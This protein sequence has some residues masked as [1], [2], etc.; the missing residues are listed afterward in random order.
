MASLSKVVPFTNRGL[1]MSIVRHRQWFDHE[2]RAWILQSNL[3]LHYIRNTSED[4]QDEDKKAEHTRW[5]RI[6]EEQRV[7]ETTKPELGFVHKVEYRYGEK[8]LFSSLGNEKTQVSFNRR[9]AD[10][11]KMARKRNETVLKNRM[12]NKSL[13]DRVVNPPL[14]E[15]AEAKMYGMDLAAV[16]KRITDS[17][18]PTDIAAV[19][20]GY[21]GTS[22]THIYDAWWANMPEAQRQKMI[23]ETRCKWNKLLNTDGTHPTPEASARGDIYQK[24]A[25]IM[26]QKTTAP[27]QPKSV[28]VQNLEGVIGSQ[29]A[30]VEF[31]IARRDEV[32]ANLVQREAKVLAMIG[33]LSALERAL[34]EA[35][36]V[37]A[38]KRK[39]KK[40]VAK[41]KPVVKPKAV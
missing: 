18:S 23:E 2:K 17:M 1:K 24:A 34:A 13:I 3:G 27:E 19:Q 12:W 16:E 36:R 5:L 29:R 8:Y 14:F 21:N 31:A 35:N 20:L 30:E 9:A 7:M 37:P 22:T 39:A 28:Y 38:K 40:K 26:M 32:K 15:Q 10:P 33:L 6:R 41:N 11:Y 25:E 4:R